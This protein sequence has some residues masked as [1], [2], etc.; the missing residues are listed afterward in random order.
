MKQGWEVIKLGDICEF[1]NGLWK[2]KKPPFITAKVIRMTN[3]TRECEM[4]EI[5]PIEIE[6]EK[7]QFLTRSLVNGDLILEKSGGG[8]NQPVGRV[9]RFNTKSNEHFSFSNFTTRLRILNNESVDSKYLHKYLK[10][11]YMLGKTEKFQN[12]STNIRNLNLPALKE[13]SIPIPPL[14]EQKRIVEKLDECLEAIDKATANVEKNLH[15]TKELFQSQLNRIFSKKGEGWEEKKLGEVC[16]LYQGLA[17]NK[18]TKHLLVKKSSLPLLRIKDLKNNT[19]ELYVSESGYPSKSLVNEKEIIYTRTGSLGLVF[20]GRKGVLH[21]NSFK[22]IP[23]EDIESDFLFWWLQHDAFRNKILSL[24]KKMAQP[25]ITHKIFKQQKINIP[26]IQEQ[27]L[28]YRQIKELNRYTKNIESNYQQKLNAL[29]ELKK[30]I[31][32]KAFNGEL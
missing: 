32:K 8:P 20:R 15:N 26:P 10:Y 13:I 31:L 28:F 12:N 18:K 19:S 30:S 2:G 1:R 21:N 16:E 29:D 4:N 27:K 6:V 3:F 22:I 7:K 11:F 25:D 5:E 23:K 24:A 14:D 9:V 17:I